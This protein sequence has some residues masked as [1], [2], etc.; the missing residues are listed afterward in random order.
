MTDCPVC[1]TGKSASFKG[2]LN[3]IEIQPS[4]FGGNKAK[5]KTSFWRCWC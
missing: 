2:S 3:K 1:F 4:L 5:L